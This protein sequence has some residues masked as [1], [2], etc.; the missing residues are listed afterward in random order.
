MGEVQDYAES[1]DSERKLKDDPRWQLVQRI[2]ASPLF[3]K[4]TRLSSF[5][6]YVCDQT[7]LGHAKDIN[8]QSIGEKVFERG[9]GYDP[10]LD[11]IVRVYARK[12][13]ERLDEYFF[14]HGIS[15]AYVITIPRGGYVPIFSIR[16]SSIS[17]EQLYEIEKGDLATPEAQNQKDQLSSDRT[18]SIS[19]ITM[20]V[21]LVIVACLG[22][23]Y[24][25]KTRSDR[26]D[27]SPSE[28]LWSHLLSKDRETIVVP[29]DSSLVILQNHTNHHVSL[30]EYMT[31]TYISNVVCAAPCQSSIEANVAQR[32][33]TS[34]VDLKTAIAFEKLSNAFSKTLQVRYAR[35]VRMDDL[36]NANMIFVGA[37][38]AD[39]WLELFQNHLTFYIEDDQAN[40][41]LAVK[42]GLHPGASAKE[43][44]YL[45]NDPQQHAYA[46]I[47]FIRNPMG[48][49]DVLI[50]QGTTMGG[51]EAAAS[52]VL[53]RNAMD[54]LLRKRLDKDGKLHYFEL[55]LETRNLNG[56]A[57]SSEVIASRF[58]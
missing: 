33:Y 28:M 35:D 13:R 2:V 48:E 4:S 21:F 32:R 12:L 23:G 36:K 56:N 55:L 14:T 54:S 37:R 20:I 45:S 39:P 58:Y 17:G 8:E 38:E 5:L 6:E 25:I 51:T 18:R 3:T 46:A 11:N 44:V 43:Y 29:A 26:R 52:F 30:S 47:A 1:I 22:I 19:L 50:L 7:L 40:R 27:S 57:S 41:R 34:I 49:G 10:G 42:N 15:E 24:V 53:D 16:P 31:G 9:Q